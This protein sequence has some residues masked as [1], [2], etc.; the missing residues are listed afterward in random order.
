MISEHDIE[1]AEF[2]DAEYSAMSEHSPVVPC[3]HSSKA[4]VILAGLAMAACWVETGHAQQVQPPHKT[5][6]SEL[7]SP[8]DEAMRRKLQPFVHCLNTVGNEMPRLAQAYLQAFAVLNKNPRQE[9]GALT[10]GFQQFYT[11]GVLF[12]SAAPDECAAGLGKASAMPP[13]DPDLD[14]LATR[15]ATALHQMDIVAPKVETYYK[16]KNYQDDK[17]AAGRTMNAEYEPLLKQI[18]A[19]THQ[20][21]VEVQKRTDAIDARRVDAIAQ[22]DGKHGRWEANAF[23]VQARVTIRTL[24]SLLADKALHKDQVVAAV[25]PLE[26]RYEEADAYFKAHPEENTDDMNLWDKAASSAQDFVT[27]TKQVRRDATDGKPADFTG[28]DIEWARHQYDGLIAS[29][30][31]SKR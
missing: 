19:D 27:A 6:E 8:D 10:Y 4:Y 14:A 23:M 31:I 28:A 20:M 13:A 18:R 25:T 11:G 22:H 5:P 15:Y 29:A 12:T 16:E 24:D 21:F 17:M 1:G 26:A 3:G 9:V 30:N 2:L 7:L